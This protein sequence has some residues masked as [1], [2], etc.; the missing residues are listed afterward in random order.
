MT[1][2]AA[3]LWF[4]TTIPESRDPV[5]CRNSTLSAHRA[6][7]ALRRLLACAAGFE[8]RFPAEGQYGLFR[9]R[10]AEVSREFPEVAYYRE[11]SEMVR[12]GADPDLMHS[13]AAA[14]GGRADPSPESVFETGGRTVNRSMDLWPLLLALAIL[15]NLVELVAR[16]G[17]LPV[18]GR[19]A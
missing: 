8:A 17:W 16:K 1:R 14:T 18:L 13:I 5:P 4:A 9:I 6:T 11:S 2:E 7:G 19:W 3:R 12:W 10:P 15:L